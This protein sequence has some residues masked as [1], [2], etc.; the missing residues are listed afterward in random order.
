MTEKQK[1][2]YL[3]SRGLIC[4]YC[5]SNNLRAG[6]TDP[7]D[8]YIFQSITCGSCKKEWTDQYK[9]TDVTPIERMKDLHNEI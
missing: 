2:K 4:P 5:G 9:L 3:K 6:E 8:Y 7:Q 1:K